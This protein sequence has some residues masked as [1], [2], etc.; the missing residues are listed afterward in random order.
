MKKTYIFLSMAALLVVGA[1]MTGCSNEDNIA[2]PQQPVNN[3]NLVTLTATVS[4]DGGAAT[5]AITPSS[6]QS[7]KG[8]KTFEAENSIAVI[9][10][11]TGGGI[12]KAV[13]AALTA[14]DLSSN[15]TKAT[16]TVTLTNPKSD[17]DIRFIYP[18]TMATGDLTNVTTTDADATIDYS[19]LFDSQ[20]GDLE[21]LGHNY[22]LAIYD[23]AL[24]GTSFP[25]SVT[26]TN[27]L[28]ICE[29]TLKDLESANANITNAT[30]LTIKDG[31][32]T[33]TIS[34]TNSLS[35]PIY[36]AMK[37][38]A[39]TSMISFSTSISTSDYTK[40]YKK[41]VIGKALGAG[42]LYP[43]SVSMYT[44]GSIICS[45][46]S[47]YASEEAVPTGKTPVA[48]ILY[49]GDATG[50]D[51]YINGLALQLNEA[52]ELNF[53]DA[54]TYCNAV[55]NI[56][57]ASE[58]WMLPTKDQWNAMITTAIADYYGNCTN[59]INATASTYY[60][61]I[62]QNYYWSSTY[63]DVTNNIVYYVDFDRNSTPHTYTWHTGSNN[64]HNIKTRACFAF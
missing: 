40:I 54:N 15:G 36:V 48:M 13:S 25:A 1:I 21:T 55:T 23:G 11:K 3:D 42:K 17:S 62:L 34:S 22:D 9:Y 6:A 2:N 41:N 27:P 39:A 16:F 31:T 4:L 38:V 47:I 26:L 49:L 52:T 61:K 46:G 63:Q 20:N 37:P 59:F 14:A 50:K 56:S 35:T 28:A 30:T 64:V 33:Y 60:G 53:S 32:N 57:Y 43:I 19:G 24:S 7:G 45:D 12:A 10:E 58:K 5:R 18:A 29:F 8:T 51:G 44:I